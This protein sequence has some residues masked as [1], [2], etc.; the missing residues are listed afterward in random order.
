VPGEKGSRVEGIRAQTDIMPTIADLLGLDIREV[1]HIGRSAFVEAPRLSPGRYYYPSGTLLVG[2]TLFVP[3]SVGG[4]VE[5]FDVV[6]GKRV[7]AKGYE[8]AAELG[9]RANVLSD[10]AV[11]AMPLRE[12]AKPL[13]ADAVIPGADTSK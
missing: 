12:D 13:G 3:R 7:A 5:A 4:T 10:D 9:R 1:P 2:S 8:T 6:T 11:K